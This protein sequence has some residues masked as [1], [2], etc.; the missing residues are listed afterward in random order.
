MIRT[1][2]DSRAEANDPCLQWIFHIGVNHSLMPVSWSIERPENDRHRS[3]FSAV[4]ALYQTFVTQP[5]L[6]SAPTS[7]DSH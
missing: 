4:A 6:M 1:T 7:L 2:Q 5:G 3:Y